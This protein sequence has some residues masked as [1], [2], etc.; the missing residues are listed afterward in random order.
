MVALDSDY[1]GFLIEHGVCSNDVWRVDHGLDYDIFY[2]DYPD[3]YDFL[4]KVGLGIWGESEASEQE[5]DSES[6]GRVGD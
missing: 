4:A 2:T 3:L 5:V 6:E 1:Y